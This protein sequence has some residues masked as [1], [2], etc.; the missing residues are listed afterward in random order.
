[1]GRIQRTFTATDQSGQARTCVQNINIT[2]TDP[3]SLNDIT[4]PSD[5]QTSTCGG[6][7]GYSKYSI[8]L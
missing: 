8:S 1:M 2:D 3:F 6:V 5:Y 4:W 7:P